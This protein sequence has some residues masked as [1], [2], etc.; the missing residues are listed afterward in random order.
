MTGVFLGEFPLPPIH[1]PSYR[2]VRYAAEARVAAAPRGTWALLRG[3]NVN[4]GGLF[5]FPLLSDGSGSLA[6]V[7]YDHYAQP[8]TFEALAERF[9][10]REDAAAPPARG[11]SRATTGMPLFSNGG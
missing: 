6:P 8:P 2:A 11:P 4:V 3:E 10:A 7:G 1:D 9:L 5:Y